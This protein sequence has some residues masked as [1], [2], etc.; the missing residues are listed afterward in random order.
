M[1]FV[2][3]FA[4][5]MN[6]CRRQ[7]ALT[8]RSLARKRCAVVLVDL[9]GTG[10][11]EGDFSDATWDMWKSDVGTAMAWA[12]SA[13]SSV[14]AIVAT[15]LGCALAA[16]SLLEFDRSVSR[17]VFWQPVMNGR[18]FMTQFLRLQVAASMMDSGGQVTVDELRTRLEE[19]LSLEIA[20]YELTRRLWSAVEGSDLLSCL[21]RRLGRL[22]VIEVGRVKN[23]GLSVPGQRLMAAAQEEDIEVTGKRLPGDP[24]WAA[25]E[26]VT[27]SA[28]SE[29]TVAHVV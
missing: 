18:Q 24:M 26:V 4:D 22:H 28:L 9:F 20:G 5:E 1:V 13:F 23:D 14:D 16:E 27:N 11:S 12:E 15:R 25:T 7:V 21:S 6:K 29:A 10:D 19:G 17:S 3:P 8:A 2:P